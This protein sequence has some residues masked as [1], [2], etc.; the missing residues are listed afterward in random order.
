[1]VQP[2]DY[3]EVAR[4]LVE[5]P[6]TEAALRTAVSRAYFGA[7]L[8]VREA[9]VVKGVLPARRGVRD[10]LDLVATLRARPGYRLLGDMVD[11]LRLLRA[12]ADFD[13]PRTLGMTEARRAL[14][15]ARCIAE[16]V[17]QGR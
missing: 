7:F 12:H 10:A 17:S 4:A 16:R 8:L 15:L 6:R 11:E 14:T 5:G 3:V 9:L 1:M 2:L 13:H